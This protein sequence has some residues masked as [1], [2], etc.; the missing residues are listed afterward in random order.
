MRGKYCVLAGILWDAHMAIANSE[1]FLLQVLVEGPA[2]H[3]FS[4]EGP[5]GYL[6]CEGSGTLIIRR[7]ADAEK[8]GQRVLAKI[9]RCVSGSAGPREGVEEGPGRIYEQPCAF[10]MKKM[11]ERA[12]VASAVSLERLQYMGKSCLITGRI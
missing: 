3:P 6:R 5:F 8:D 1:P 7:L 4:D 12:Y 10:G 2:S 11:F 9:L